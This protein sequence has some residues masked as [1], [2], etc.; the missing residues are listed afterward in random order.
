[1]EERYNYFRD[2]KTRFGWGVNDSVRDETVALV[3]DKG[4]AK[5]LSDIMNGK[6]CEAIEFAK[7]NKKYFDE[8]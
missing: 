3:A 1:M 7:D 6:Y 8:R 2:H 4:Y 5:I